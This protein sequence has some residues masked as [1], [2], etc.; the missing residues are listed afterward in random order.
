MGVPEGEEI[1]DG[2]NIDQDFSKWRK[3]PKHRLKKLHGF[4]EGKIQIKLY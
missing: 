1:Q 4:Q 2:G 3:I